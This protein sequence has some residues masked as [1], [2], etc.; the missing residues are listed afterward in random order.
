LFLFFHVGTVEYATW[1]N[2][3][4]TIFFK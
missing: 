3:S 1:K 4:K 2:P